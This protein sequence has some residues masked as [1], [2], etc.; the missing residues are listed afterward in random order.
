MPRLS[1]DISEQQHQHL[2]VIAALNGQTIKDFVLSRTFGE[3]AAQEELSEEAALQA[4]QRFLAERLEQ[5]KSG[6]IVERS[7]AD[8]KMRARQ[9]RDGGV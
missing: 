5:V 8:I 1:I 9:L 2:K 7:A 6:Q 4:L 3:G